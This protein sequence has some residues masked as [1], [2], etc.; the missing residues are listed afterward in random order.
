MLHIYQILSSHVHTLET[1]TLNTS[2]CP[3]L[4][5]HQCSL[6]PKAEGGE[7]TVYWGYQTGE[8]ATCPGFPK[9]L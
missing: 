3:G 2:N 6:M 8:L 4:L 9:V 1:E 7:F 5:I